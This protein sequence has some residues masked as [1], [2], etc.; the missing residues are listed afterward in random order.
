VLA[1]F[2]TGRVLDELSFGIIVLDRQLCAI[3]ANVIAQSLL[4]LHLPS[5]R[6]RPLADYLAQP[7][8]FSYFVRRALEGGVAVDYAIRIG[9]RHR[10]E[11]VEA[12][13]L[14]IVPLC[15]QTARGYLLV[16]LSAGPS[17]EITDPEA[18]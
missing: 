17:L 1:D 16:E 8:R 6:G 3:Y 2:D 7:Q 5:M 18:P 4:G 13:T 12:I 14:R 15:S 9:L 11:D 10:P